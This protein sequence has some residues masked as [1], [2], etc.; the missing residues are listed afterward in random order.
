M[1]WNLE[2]MSP[3][4]EFMRTLTA[5]ASPFDTTDQMGYTCEVSSHWDGDK[6]VIVLV[7]KTEGGKGYSIIREVIEQGIFAV[8]SPTKR[9]LFL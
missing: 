5:G 4:H 1:I 8:C 6:F 2:N 7:S 9:P 3:S